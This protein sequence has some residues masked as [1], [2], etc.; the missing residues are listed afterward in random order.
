MICPFTV[1]SEIIDYYI[2]RPV[3]RSFAGVMGCFFGCFRSR[4]D[5]RHNLRRPHP[6]FSVSKTEVP[7][8]KNR[9]SSLFSSEDDEASR[10]NDNEKSSFG[11][12]TITKELRDEAKFLKACGTLPETPAEIRKAFSKLKASPPPKSSES[13]KFHSWLHNESTDTIKQIVDQPSTPT[14]L[15]EEEDQ[16]RGSVPSELTPARCIPYGHNSGGINAA[17]ADADADAECVKTVAKSV[18]FDCKSDTSFSEGSPRHYD[19]HISEKTAI[20][21]LKSSPRATPLKLTDDMQ[22]PGTVFPATMDTSGNG[23]PRIRSEYAYAVINPVENT[24]HWKDLKESPHLSCELRESLEQS[25]NATISTSVIG[26]QETSHINN[27]AEASLS[28]WVKPP[29]SKQDDDHPN[30]GTMSTKSYHP[31]RTPE[32]RPII[33]MVAAHWNEH[34]PSDIPPKWWD[35]NGIPNSTNKYKEDQK[36][37]WHATPFEERLEKALSEESVVS[38]KKEISGRPMVFEEFEETDTAISQFHSSSQTKSVV[39]F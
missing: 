26:P 2:F 13:S 38:K 4:D 22:T 34:E 32:D 37:S 33:G 6:H 5:R 24:S 17:D 10:R 36:V 28:S 15:G 20:S 25:E 23:K 11:S 19:C 3:L 16:A 7:V 29:P 1:E 12:P 14:K 35:G 21:T 30:V 31:R 18:R 9:L 8:S 39:S 27:L